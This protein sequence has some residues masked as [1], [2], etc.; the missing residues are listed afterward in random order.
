MT[1]SIVQY[2]REENNE[3]RKYTHIVEL[4]ERNNGHHVMVSY[5]A[6]LFDVAGIGN[7]CVGLT[8]YEMF[9]FADKMKQ[10]WCCIK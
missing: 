6:S 1:T 7:S 3:G 5:D 10:L 8:V 2:K 4:Q 9:A